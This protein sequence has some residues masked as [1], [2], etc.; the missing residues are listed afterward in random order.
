MAIIF[1]SILAEISPK[2]NG[3]K[4]IIVDKSIRSRASVSGFADSTDAFGSYIEIEIRRQ[5]CKD[6]G[7]YSCVCTFAKP[8]HKSENTTATRDVI[9]PSMYF[10]FFWGVHVYKGMWYCITMYNGPRGIY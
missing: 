4:P 3:G 8:G 2:K 1:R 5:A 6:S 7:D 9:V 10:F